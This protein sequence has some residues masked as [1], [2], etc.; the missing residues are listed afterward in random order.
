MKRKKILYIF[1]V[2][3]IGGGSIC[4][5]NMIKCLDTT[6]FIP[7]VLLKSKG[8]LSVEFESRGVSVFFE[9]SIS[10]IPYNQS[11]FCF[12]SIKL[13]WSMVVSLNR[14]KYWVKKTDAEIVHLN[15]M[16]MYPY[17]IPAFKLGRKVIVHMREHWPQNEHKIQFKFAR[18]II[19]Q[20]SS[21]II[22]INRT[23]A[24]LLN[25]PNKTEI[26]YD[27]I[28]FENR[29]GEIDLKKNY[30]VDVEKD[31]VFLF[32]GGTQLI[33]GALEV[34]S[35]F[36]NE[37]KQKNVKLILLGADEIKFSNRGLI[38]FLKKI[39]RSVNL[40][41]KGD[42]L[43][44][45]LQDEKRIIQIPRTK[46]VLSLYQQVY[47]VIAFP[48]IPH[49]ILPIAESLWNGTPIISADTLEA[50]EYSN[51]GKSAI[52]IPMHNKIALKDAIIDAINNENEIK[53]LALEGIDYIREKFDPKTNSK[54][55]DNIY[56]GLL[57]ED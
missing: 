45:I 30:G 41:V 21:K 11:L 29:D 38:A 46:N 12:S 14:I 54:I 17:A 31:K 15:T 16:M 4:L 8:P 51:N 56:S 52:L 44:K 13:Y 3:E 25:I 9:K 33:K 47:C 27:W 57:I 26:V 39:L 20:F 36:S 22:A 32:L 50:R 43:K 6:K 34:V 48:T 23:S 19:N 42:C 7:I 5:L 28:D 49:A 18:Y 1:H 40:P 2:S 53:D 10:T 35:V 55:L 24:N 37:I